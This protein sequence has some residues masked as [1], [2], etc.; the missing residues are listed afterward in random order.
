MKS[1]KTLVCMVALHI[2][3]MVFGAAQAADTVRLTLM[4]VNDVY[5]LG[6]VDKG[7]NGGLARLATQV[8]RIRQDTTNSLFI[9]GGDTLS[10]SMASNTFRG[11]QMIAD[12]SEFPWLAANV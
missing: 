8:Q 9:F 12:E 10:P 4:H 7:K 3:P 11:A 5:Q 2:L 6:P 1:I